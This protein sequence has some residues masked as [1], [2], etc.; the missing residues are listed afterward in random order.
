M[1]MERV[2]AFRSQFNSRLLNSG[3]GRIPT[4]ASYLSGKPW[5]VP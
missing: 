5:K 4:S 3:P 2:F 1:K